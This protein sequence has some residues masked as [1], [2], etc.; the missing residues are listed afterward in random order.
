MD[1]TE[2]LERVASSGRA[3][4]GMIRTMTEDKRDFCTWYVPRAGGMNVKVD[5][6]WKYEQR[7]DAVAASRK[8][9]AQA[10]QE[11]RSEDD[12]GRV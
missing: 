9:I 5:G 1:R 2:F 10:R 7:E 8:I 4:V 12:D 6:R 3:S 11:L